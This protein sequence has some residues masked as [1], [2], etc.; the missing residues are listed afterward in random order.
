MPSKYSKYFDEKI[1]INKI[2]EIADEMKLNNDNLEDL[3]DLFIYKSRVKCGPVDTD[4]IYYN[5]EEYEN[6]LNFL[7]NDLKLNI[8]KVD[9]DGDTI[10]FDFMEMDES[11]HYCIQEVEILVK[12]GADINHENLNGNTPLNSLID[13]YYHEYSDI[14]LGTLLYLGADY[15]YLCKSENGRNIFKDWSYFT[16]I[17]NAENIKFNDIN[18]NGLDFNGETALTYC[19]KN[20]YNMRDYGKD[21]IK[22]LLDNRADINLPNSKG[23]FPLK[24]S[25]MR[26]RDYL[27]Q[28]NNKKLEDAAWLKIFN[29][30]FTLNDLK[31][32]SKKANV[33]ITN[34]YG[35]NALHLF[36]SA[37]IGDE[38]FPEPNEYKLKEYEEILNY[39]VN[40]LKI[41]INHKDEDN[42]TPIFKFIVQTLLEQQSQ[43]FELYIKYGADINATT[44][45]DSVLHRA[46]SIYHPQDGNDVFTEILIEKGINIYILCGLKNNDDKITNKSEKYYFYKWKYLYMIIQDLI[47]VKIDL[48]KFDF[49]EY[50]LSGET[51]LTASIKYE[52][53]FC[54]FIFHEDYYKILFKYEADINKRNSKN[55]SVLDL[56]NIE[57]K[58]KLLE[59]FQLNN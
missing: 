7:V 8:N 18:F 22:I 12:Y 29:K 6:I 41:N 34:S 46:I 31:E 47:N 26:V 44:S 59:I 48:T 51:S 3:L 39:L 49:N 54:D 27:L 56:V 33:H 2:K 55:E 38:Y 20:D 9:D 14:M 21:C 5:Q 40:E 25:S 17:Y 28:Y 4:F 43:E 15:H 35:A 19:I 13:C 45:Y 53:N 58:Q 42:E 23:E 16:K 36:T 37:C 50:D 24:I 11:F 32:S 30:K 57:Y 1:N 10:I 52:N